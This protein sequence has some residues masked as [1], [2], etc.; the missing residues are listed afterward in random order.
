MINI[1][2]ATEMD[3][4][5]I[6]KIRI[7]NW[8]KTYKGLLPQAFLDDLTYE[9]ETLDWLHFDQ[10]EISSVFVA[11]AENH[12]ILGFVAIQPFN[13]EATIGEIY[14]LHTAEA[15]RGLGIGKALIYFSAKQFKAHQINEM[16]LWVVDGNNQAIAIYEHLGAEVYIKRI[17][18][19]DWADVPEIGMKWPNLN[20]IDKI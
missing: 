5:T 13:E 9:K 1:R 12:S 6:A 15:F 19:I 7:D 3:F 18:K 16:R 2:L 8:R 14:A 17:A 11:T 4:P 20:L 10:S